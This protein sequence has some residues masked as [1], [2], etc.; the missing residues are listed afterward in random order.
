M[1]DGYYSAEKSNNTV[2]C[3]I[4]KEPNTFYIS[5]VDLLFGVAGTTGTDATLVL[6][7]EDTSLAAIKCF[8]CWK[9]KYNCSFI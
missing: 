8:H 9:Y 4:E 2:Q 5:T 7:F 1:I 6:S 3:T